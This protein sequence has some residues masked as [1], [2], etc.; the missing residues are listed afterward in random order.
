[1]R[2]ASVLVTIVALALVPMI[3]FSAM[4]RVVAQESTPA[5]E[6]GGASDTARVRPLAA[7]AIDILEPGTANI[8]LGRLVLPP[9]GSL[10]FDA[11]DSSASMIYVQ[12]GTMTFVVDA[13]VA[14]S[15]GGSGTP[16]AGQSEP[17]DA[18]AEFTLD[19]DDAALFSPN[20]S[21]EV[22]N[23]GTEEAAA[24]VVSLAHVTA[25]AGTPTP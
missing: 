19:R 4:P 17:Q 23:D 25:P 10:P 24:L 13:L 18:G 20:I 11:N 14:V 2:R 22:R 6:D 1:M 15:R 5:A 16:G 12:S 9:G 3:V 8:V 7:A 21:G